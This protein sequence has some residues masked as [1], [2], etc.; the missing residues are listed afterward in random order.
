MPV[1]LLS[2]ADS[3]KKYESTGDEYIEWYFTIL[4]IILGTVPTRNASRGRSID[5]SDD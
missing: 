1:L 2:I 3:I 5:V 4:E